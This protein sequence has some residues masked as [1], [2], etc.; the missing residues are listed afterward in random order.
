MKSSRSTK[1]KFYEVP[2]LERKRE[3]IVKV[4]IVTEKELKR[5]QCIEKT[6]SSV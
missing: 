1:Q 3:N 2:F 5:T 4:Q 6:N